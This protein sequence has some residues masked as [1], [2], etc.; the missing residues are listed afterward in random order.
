MTV[1]SCMK[2]VVMGGQV[3]IFQYFMF[4]VGTNSKS[5]DLGIIHYTRPE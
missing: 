5:Y 1:Q 4:F 2:L 3:V